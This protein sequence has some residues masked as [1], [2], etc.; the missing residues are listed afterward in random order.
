MYNSIVRG[1][2]EE[3]RFSNVIIFFCF[4]KLARDL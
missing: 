3:E 4:E 1:K 2:E